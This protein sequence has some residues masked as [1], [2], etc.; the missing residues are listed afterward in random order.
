MRDPARI[1]EFC[2]TFAEL[3]KRNAPDWRFGQLICNIFESD[4]FYLEDD[5]ALAI[6]KA[7][8]G[9]D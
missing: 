8:F 2:D 3:W 6:I 5:E 4:P 1:K 7:F 9:E